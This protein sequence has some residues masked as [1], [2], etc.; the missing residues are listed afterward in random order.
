M[1]STH[2]PHVVKEGIGMPQSVG[3]GACGLAGRHMVC[4]TASNYEMTGA[5][6]P[7]QPDAPASAHAARLLLFVPLPRTELCGTHDVLSLAPS[8]PTGWLG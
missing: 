2:L 4:N 6:L 8:C 3:G 7:A 1:Q 5:A